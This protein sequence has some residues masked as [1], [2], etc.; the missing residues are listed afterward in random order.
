MQDFYAHSNYVERN[1]KDNPNLRPQDIPLFEFTDIPAGRAKDVHTG[2][3]YYK[4]SFQNEA[5]EFWLGRSGTIGNLDSLNMKIPGTQYLPTEQ[6]DKLSSFTDR[7]NYFTDPKYSVLHF[8]INKDD[9]KS[10][11]G[12]L[13]DTATNSKLFDYARDLAFRE[14]QRQWSQFEDTVHKVHGKAEGDKVLQQ[15]KNISFSNSA[16][17]SLRYSLDGLITW[18]S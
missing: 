15:I 2:F 8:D 12:K 9:E 3:Y 16:L 17:R 13:V 11:E 10:V 14:T 4:N 5:T 7:M 1:L 18:I 6:Y